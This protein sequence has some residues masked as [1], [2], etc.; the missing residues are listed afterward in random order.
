M[1][2]PAS[3]SRV[4]HQPD[5]GGQRIMESSSSLY[6]ARV[7]SAPQQVAHQPQGLLAVDSAQ[8]GPSENYGKCYISPL[9]VATK[10]FRL[11]ISPVERRPENLHENCQGI[12]H[13]LWMLYLTPPQMLVWFK[14]NYGYRTIWGS[15]ISEL[16]INTLTK[17]CEKSFPSL[18][19]CIDFLTDVC[20]VKP[21]YGYRT[22]WGCFI[23]EL[24]EINILTLFNI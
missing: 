17:A 13:V 20:V 11:C 12:F 10:P 9:M 4:V 7:V 16:Q 6:P 8:Q 19:G 2:E 18:E 22:G 15:S 23:S 14:L 21:M 3:H 24:L 5:K 1:G